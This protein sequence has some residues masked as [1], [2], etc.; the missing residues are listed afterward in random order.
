MDCGWIRDGRK[1]I[2]GKRLVVVAGSKIM[3]YIWNPVMVERSHDNIFKALLT[4]RALNIE[5]GIL[6]S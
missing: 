1:V 5:Q 4:N 3:Q 6:Y 2:L